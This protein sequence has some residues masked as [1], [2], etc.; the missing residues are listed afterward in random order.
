[1]LAFFGILILLNVWNCF[2]VHTNA[3]PFNY[4]SNEVHLERLKVQDHSVS[5][6]PGTA[7]SPS[8]LIVIHV[9][10]IVRWRSALLWRTFF[11]TAVVAVVLRSFIEFCRGGECG[12]FGEGGL[13]M[14]NINTE[15]S[16]YGTPDL[17]A[18][19]LLGVFGGVLGSLYNYLV[20]KVLRTYSII[21]EY[22]PECLFIMIL[23]IKVNLPPSFTPYT[24]L[25]LYRF[26]ITD[27]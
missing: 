22:A 12:L 7:F 6:L 23:E 19:V 21:N 24:I 5:Y 17:I 15:N 9:V 26:T 8:S 10:E 1:M 4:I 25:L 16:T 11:T 13:I 18:I 3:L 2:H 20:D 14:F 27:S